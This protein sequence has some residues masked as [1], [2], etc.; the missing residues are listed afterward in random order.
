M[1]YM[2][3]QKAKR[4][5]QA[6][7]TLVELL[8]SVGIMAFIIAGAMAL[9]ISTS[10]TQ[11]NNETLAT[12]TLY[13]N[14]MAT[15]IKNGTAWQYD[16]TNVSSTNNYAL[17]C[18]NQN[19]P[20]SNSL[21]VTPT[22]TY[23]DTIYDARGNIFY[24]N[25]KQISTNGF[26]LQGTACTTFKTAA[27]GGND[28]CPF[29]WDLG[30]TLTCSDTTM[31]QCLEPTVT[32]TGTL[33]YSPT[34]KA[35]VVLNKQM[36]IIN[37]SEYSFTVT[38]A[39][40][41]DGLNQFLYVAQQ[42]TGTSNGGGTCTS[43]GTTYRNYSTGSASA[44][45][46]ASTNSNYVPAVNVTSTLLQGNILDIP[47]AGSGNNAIELKAG[48]YVCDIMATAWAVDAWTLNVYV[49]PVGGSSVIKASKTGY[50]R[51]QYAWASQKLI[52]EK[53]FI[54]LSTNSYLQVQQICQ[55]AP[56]PGAIPSGGSPT[57]TISPNYAMGLPASLMGL[58]SGSGYT[59]T[60]NIYSSIGCTRVY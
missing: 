29:R 19:Q 44:V 7:T 18:L 31:T 35:G 27:N 14:Q 12:L 50:A 54:N 20:C 4:R 60:S 13:K 16:I 56:N 38:R 28:A 23:L 51:Q 32:V 41:A 9:T 58:T 11:I 59:N 1:L 55:N 6:G 17:N 52:I 48:G 39:P 2:T 3:S 5:H 46:L 24:S 26:S 36:P 53:L 45:D 25:P 37:T 34:L 42:E 43:T 40:A 57:F 47:A 49:M 8:V 15:Y 22:Y 33:E 10:Q 21:V 30:V